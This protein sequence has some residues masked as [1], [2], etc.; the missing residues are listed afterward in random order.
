MDSPLLELETL[1]AKALY[2]LL[3]DQSLTDCELV[4]SDG[5]VLPAHRIILAASSG[6]FRA[7][8]CGAWRQQQE[9]CGP[10]AP[11]PQRPGV[12]RWT[13]SGVDGPSLQ[14]LLAAIYSKRLPLTADGV[15][16]DIPRLLA[17]S[18][19]LEVLPVKEACCQYLRS[20]LSLETVAA[21]LSLAA[22]HD[23]TD[24]LADA[25][26][27]FEGHFSQLL[28]SEE[29]SSLAVLPPDLL[30][31]LLS[32]DGLCIQSE[33]DVAHA[34]LLW[35]AADPQQRA[36]LLLELLPAARMPPG[37]LAREA[38]RSGLLGAGS[39]WLLQAAA[40]QPGQQQQRQQHD[41]APPPQPPTPQQG[42]SA[43]DVSAE[44]ELGHAFVAACQQLQQSQPPGAVAEGG[45]VAASCSYGPEAALVAYRPRLSSP[46]GLMMAGGLDDGWR[47]LRTVELYD[48][49][50]DAWAAG[51]VMPAPASFAA[52][53]MLGGQLYVVEGA[54][55]APHVLSFERHKRLWG[56]CQPLAKPRVNM[57]VCAL[58]DRLYVLGGRAG[59]G[60]GASVLRDVEIYDPASNS[61]CS[62]APMVQPRAALGAA[63]LGGRIYA[64][65]GQSSR[66]CHATVEC[67][68]PGA[69]RWVELGGPMHTA[70][71]YLG[72]AAAGGRLIAVGGMTGARMRLQAAEA[73]DPREGRWQALP[74]APLARSSFGIAM[75][76]DCV[77]AVGG[78]IGT[79]VLNDSTVRVEAFIPAAGRWRAC[80]PISHGRSGLALA[81]L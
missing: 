63:A 75:L 32:S 19:Y 48:P 77:Y 52:A 54:A 53:A 23:C 40:L 38:A 59:I 42:R 25:S 46:T 71:K 80:S 65:G 28:K 10:A 66:A 56:S 50:R 68:E 39:A 64:V 27:F 55:H 6:F 61:W 26:R 43:A 60:K 41:E 11:A 3:L 37:L 2:G 47:A 29:S 24:L 44:L 17:A 31:T 13:L 45:S 36:P 33:V 1:P 14:L 62:G 15:S 67:W 76:H 8:L 12:E 51:P 69:E 72:L 5:A 73:L 21:T 74:P 78:N 79:E 18:N 22:A 49:R 9:G 81:P 34:A 70:R 20:Q 30:R 58:E 35:A 16:Q 7:L 4:A 57:A